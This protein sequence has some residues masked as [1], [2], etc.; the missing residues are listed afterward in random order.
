[1]PTTMSRAYFTRFQR[2]VDDRAK[3]RDEKKVRSEIRQEHKKRPEQCVHALPCR[4]VFARESKKENCI[5]MKN[6]EEES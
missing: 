2:T 4:R 5:I 6:N 1:M 3:R